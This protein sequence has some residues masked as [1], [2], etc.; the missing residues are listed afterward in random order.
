[1]PQY[2][3]LLYDDPKGVEIFRNMGPAEIQAAIA[4]YR[5]WGDRLR[6]DGLLVASH[7]LADEGG[8]RVERDGQ[9]VR[10][11][12]GPFTEAKEVLGGYYTITASSYQ[13]AI[14]RALH[15]CPHLEHGSVVIREI[16]I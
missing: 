16:E 12:D 13:D 6:S 9:K 3:L 1:M 2:M 5:A 14:D 7:K 11:T 10:V 4:Q 15:D 8:K